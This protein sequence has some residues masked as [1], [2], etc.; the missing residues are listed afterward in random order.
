MC[1]TII[2]TIRLRQTIRQKL[3]SHFGNVF[4]GV[5]LLEM[6]FLFYLQ[7][8]NLTLIDSKLASR[9]TCMLPGVFCSGSSASL[10]MR[11]VDRSVHKTHH[12][13]HNTHMK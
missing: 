1:W 6:R 7:A 5:S 4:S 13:Q 12:L 11:V 10:T 8:P 9:N 2:Y 3:L